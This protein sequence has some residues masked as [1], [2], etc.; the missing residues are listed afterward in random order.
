M[1][2]M[3]DVG[4]AFNCA[5]ELDSSLICNFDGKKEADQWV[6][7]NKDSV[8]EFK[9]MKLEQKRKTMVNKNIIMGSKHTSSDLLRRYLQGHDCAT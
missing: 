4:E 2:H 1:S 6:A 7:E 3:L 5:D 9:N 8:A